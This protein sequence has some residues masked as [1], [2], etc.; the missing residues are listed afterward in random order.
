MLA[1]SAL[2]AWTVYCL[3]F[4]CLWFPWS[5]AMFQRNEAGQTRGTPS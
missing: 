4:A 5:G 2:K 3:K 1:R